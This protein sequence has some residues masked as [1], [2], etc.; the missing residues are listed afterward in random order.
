MPNKAKTPKPG[1][2]KKR[3]AVACLL[4][5]AAVAC[6]A[7]YFLMRNDL[8][9][10]AD[11][12]VVSARKSWTLD[13]KTFYETGGGMQVLET[14]AVLFRSRA[15]RLSGKDVRRRLVYLFGIA[16]RK[17]TALSGDGA[18][19]LTGRTGFALAL[20][21]VLAAIGI[22]TAASR[23]RRKASEPLGKPATM[24]PK[25]DG[26]AAVSPRTVMLNDVVRHFFRLYRMQSKAPAEAP[27]RIEPLAPEPESPGSR[28]RLGIRFDNDW[29]WRYMTIRPIG[30][31]A[32]SKSQCF[33]VIYDTHIVVKIPPVPIRDFSDYIRRIQFES[34][35][36]HALAPRKCIIPNVSVILGK[37]HRFDDA[38]LRSAEQLEEDYI[39]LLE[40]TPALHHCLK[41]DEE[42]AFFMDL[43]RDYFLS[44]A[45]AGPAGDDPRSVLEEDVN[46]I[47]D[48][49]GFELRYGADKGWICLELQSLYHRF[50]AELGPILHR[51][52]PEARPTEPQKRRWFH[53]RLCDPSAP[54]PEGPG[55]AGAAADLLDRLFAGKPGVI[56][57]YRNLAV[58]YARRVSFGRTRPMKE[59]LATNLLDLLQW[60]EQCRVA[61]RDLKPDNLLVTG[62]SAR[63]PTFLADSEAFSIGLIDLET[64]V[65]CPEGGRRR[66]QPQLGGTPTYATPSHFLPNRL[67]EGFY[68]DIDRVF[69]LQDW[70]AAVGI[71]FSVVTGARLFGRTAGLFPPM[72]RALTAASAAKEP[73]ED[74]FRVHNARFWKT[75]RAEYA[76]QTEKYAELLE[77]VSVQVPVSMSETLTSFFDR[78]RDA[79]A[80]EVDAAVR[81][82]D[83]V[84]SPKA[85]K[86]LRNC[87]Y[88]AVVR[89][90]E[91]AGSNG[92]ISQERLRR[93]FERLCALKRR[94]ERFDRL[95]RRFG[96]GSRGGMPVKQLLE[97]MF[98]RIHGFLG[99]TGP[100]AE[101]PE[102]APAESSVAETKDETL[103]YTHS[104]R[105][106]DGRNR[107]VA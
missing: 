99:D 37:V 21:L 75:A 67:L 70:Y 100:A 28:F 12:R 84:R 107:D 89:A 16:K 47:E 106:Q 103:S 6:A 24:G 52:D 14:R 32:G 35:V 93:L 80:R 91:K 76:R 97:A 95:A 102:P 72:I 85:Q 62:D 8:L 40:R 83:L 9:F 30:E 88:R 19:A 71:I 15:F 5:A 22:G 101:A 27:G 104:A 66:P 10:L 78:E 17:W 7:A 23:N 36:V 92:S 60:L 68:V 3:L 4:A 50:D 44:H 25:S 39:R 63:Y 31:T 58:P 34:E 65:V 41:I 13:D 46:L 51:R 18:Y 64:A 48:C 59:A 96:T 54:L 74:A 69:F 45:M 57:G 55:G 38:S 33:Y 26:S 53:G 42:F 20:V 79:L 98:E 1:S 49:R 56:D 82:Q 2:R 81:D 86:E 73:L 29:K 105:L 11:G 43:S 94:K 77:A 90:M 61:L 87:S